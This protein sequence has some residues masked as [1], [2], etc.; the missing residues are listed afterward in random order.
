[1]CKSALQT[2]KACSRS[3]W[4]APLYRNT[5]ISMDVAHP[6]WVAID[7]AASLYQLYGPVLVTAADPN[8]FATMQANP[9]SGVPWEPQNAGFGIKSNAQA[10]LG[11]KS[12]AQ[13]LA[14]RGERGSTRGSMG[15]SGVPTPLLDPPLKSRTRSWKNSTTRTEKEGKHEGKVIS[16]TPYTLLRR[17]GG[18]DS[19]RQGFPC[20]Y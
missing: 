14:A 7:F 11:V 2:T 4:F 6:S 1:M 5:Q 8:A 3:D 16:H 17:V 15:V 13:A 10:L 9:G 12:A 18:H 19:P 20:I